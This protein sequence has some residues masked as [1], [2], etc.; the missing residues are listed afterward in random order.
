MGSDFDATPVLVGKIK[1]DVTLM[2]GDADMDRP[3]RRVKLRPRLEQIELRGDRL[4]VQ[5]AS[6]GLVVV[7]TQP[8]AKALA[9]DGPGFPVTIDEEISKGGAG[10]GMK[11][12]ATCRK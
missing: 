3:L 8:P 2:L 6:R 5:G 4:P 1:I 10:R 12:L 7:A 9:A 11:E